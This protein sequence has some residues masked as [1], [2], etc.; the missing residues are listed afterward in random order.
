MNISDFL[1]SKIGHMWSNS[2]GHAFPVECWP[3][4]VIFT[5]SM[6]VGVMFLLSVFFLLCM[7][8]SWITQ[9]VMNGFWWHFPQGLIVVQWTVILIQGLYELVIC[10]S[11]FACAQTISELPEE[12]PRRQSRRPT[13]TRPPL[14]LRRN[15]ENAAR[16][17]FLRTTPLCAVFLSLK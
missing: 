15:L 11:L 14:K 10:T 16:R 3:T 8:V 5:S 9:K 13:S 2:D 6:E 1:T 7:F 4:K 17:P 12:R